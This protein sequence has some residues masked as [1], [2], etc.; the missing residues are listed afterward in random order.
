MGDGDIIS[1]RRERLMEEV[2]VTVES[3]TVGARDDVNSRWHRLFKRIA[4]VADLVMKK[5]L[6]MG[7]SILLSWSFCWVVP[8]SSSGQK[9]SQ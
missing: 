1:C 4:L 9:I 3:D 6:A 7:N 5:V 2:H 8:P